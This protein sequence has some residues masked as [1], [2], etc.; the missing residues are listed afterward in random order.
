VALVRTTPDLEQIWSVTFP[1]IPQQVFGDSKITV[2]RDGRVVLGTIVYREDYTISDLHVYIIHDSYDA[3]PETIASEKPFS[4]YPNPVKDQLSLRF[5]DGAKPESV[6]LYNLAGCLIATRRN[7][8]EDID[9]STMSSGVYM[10]H[11]T[12]KDGTSYHE[13]ILKE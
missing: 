11:V 4:L 2:L 3:T 10:L 6:E 1:E 12:M 8:I 9:M 13:K 5:D 7:D